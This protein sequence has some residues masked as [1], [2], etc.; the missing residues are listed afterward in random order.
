MDSAFSQTFL[1]EI[2]TIHTLPPL[3][4]PVISAVAAALLFVH[5]L[6]SVPAEALGA[7]AARQV[8]EGDVG[9]RDARGGRGGGHQGRGGRLGN[10]CNKKRR[11]F[12]W[13][14]ERHG[15]QKVREP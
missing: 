11:G 7:H 13:S 9:T 12:F 1:Y 2:H 10:G 8:L 6:L 14:R 3:H 4:P 15:R 5:A